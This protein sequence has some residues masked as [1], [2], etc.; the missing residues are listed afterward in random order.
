M[1]TDL[2]WSDYVFVMNPE[3]KN[4]VKLKGVEMKIV[5]EEYGD[6]LWTEP[7]VSGIIYHDDEYDLLF[8]N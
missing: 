2:R 7:F 1:V 6:S 3:L 4:S 8:L 5:N